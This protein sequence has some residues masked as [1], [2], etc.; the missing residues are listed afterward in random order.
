MVGRKHPI[1]RPRTVG[2][3]RAGDRHERKVRER[4]DDFL[5]IAFGH[6]SAALPP[7]QSEQDNVGPAAAVVV[8]SSDR[9]VG[10]SGDGLDWTNRRR[11]RPPCAADG[12]FQREN[13]HHGHSEIAHVVRENLSSG[14]QSAGLQ[15]ARLRTT[16]TT[17]G[18]TDDANVDDSGQ[19]RRNEFAIDSGRRTARFHEHGDARG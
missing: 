8:V 14:S 10:D 17:T 3:N 7:L 4:A 5:R 11:W 18:S 6:V 12:H 16:T 9:L 13:G 19:L 2:H 15:L 1:R